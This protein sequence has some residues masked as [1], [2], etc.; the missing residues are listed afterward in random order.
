MNLIEGALPFFIIPLIISFFAVP[1]C[2]QIGFKLGI[3]AQEN[4]R[5]VHHGRIVR[6]GGMAIYLAFIISM[7]IFMK[8]DKTINGI[9]LGGFVVFIGGL[10]D[11]IYDIKP[12]HKLLFQIVGAIIALTFGNTLLMNIYLPF[13]I[14]ISNPI[15]TYGISFLWIV[16]ITNA[17]NLIDGLDGLSSGISLIVTITIGLLGFFMGR[18]DISVIA[19]ILSGSIL[20]FLPYNFHPASI[21]M[22]DCGALFLG[23]TIAC[24][25]LL[26]FKTTAIITLGFPIL[27]LFIPI[28]DTLI[29][30]VRRKLSNR[31]ISEAD[32]G[33]LHHVL[34]YKLNLG[35][36]N[37]VIVLYIVASLF[38]CAAVLS[39]FNKTYGFIM[40]MILLIVAEL[41]VEVTG[42]I[43]PKFHPVIGLSRRLF[44]WPKKKEV[45]DEK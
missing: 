28:S 38:G 25:S 9:L 29:A 26:G 15:I 3:Y 12:L 14:T 45:I 31:K 35:H 10:L 17:I 7:A 43:N 27:I 23:F 36:R 42:M 24:M 16:G 32:R 6:I 21:F 18:R 37:T 40:I 41:F 30:I 34:M 13:G 22:G 20:G 8:A 39:Y 5:T 1:L 11:D 19:L 4:N 33:H 2:K 44:G